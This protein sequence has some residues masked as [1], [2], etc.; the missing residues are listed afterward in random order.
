MH[1][2]NTEV[3]TKKKCKITPSFRLVPPVLLLQL[4]QILCPALTHYMSL[5]LLLFSRFYVIYINSSCWLHE[6]ALSIMLPW[7][8]RFSPSN[9]FILLAS[10]SPLNKRNFQAQS[11]FR[12]YT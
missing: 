1:A 2:Y 11:L 8:M 7:C 6:L 3:S 9:T 10:L 12:V 4:F 5:H